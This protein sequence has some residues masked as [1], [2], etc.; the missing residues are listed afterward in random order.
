MDE[1]EMKEIFGEVISAYT[2]AD[3]LAD[4]VLIDASEIARPMGFL[5]PVAINERLYHTLGEGVEG[6]EALLQK[7]GTSWVD[8][9][10]DDG[11]PGGY[12]GFF[13]WNGEKTAISIDGGDDGNSVFTI[14]F[15]SDR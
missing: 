5:I 11:T 8:R 14:Y 9:T 3:A 7:A 13:D 1:K 4:G 15:L 12:Y 10:E 2:R 6:V